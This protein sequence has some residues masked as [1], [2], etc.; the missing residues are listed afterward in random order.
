LVVAAL[1]TTDSNGPHSN[2]ADCAKGI[3]NHIRPSIA[4]E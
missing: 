1:T 2:S 4:T 3:G